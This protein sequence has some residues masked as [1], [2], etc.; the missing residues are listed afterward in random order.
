[1]DVEEWEIYRSIEMRIIQ[2]E[3]DMEITRELWKALW[4]QE[5]CFEMKI[6]TRQ[7]FF[8]YIFLFSVIIII[9][10]ISLIDLNS[11]YVFLELPPMKPVIMVTIPAIMGIKSRRNHKKKHGL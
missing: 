3:I 7:L 10:A 1:M 8:F 11:L 2:E 5:F 6:S 4:E 9:S